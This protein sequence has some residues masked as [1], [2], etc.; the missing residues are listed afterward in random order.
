MGITGGVG[1]SGGE[2]DDLW[3]TLSYIR[4]CYYKY[5]LTDTSLPVLWFDLHTIIYYLNK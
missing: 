2:E 1:V 3:L 4:W 5:V